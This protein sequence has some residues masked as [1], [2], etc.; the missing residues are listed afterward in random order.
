V[1]AAALSGIALGQHIASQ[2]IA[3]PVDL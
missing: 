3:A 1:E 2:L